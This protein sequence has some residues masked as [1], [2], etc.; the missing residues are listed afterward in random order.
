MGYD[1]T[2]IPGDQG[3]SSPS[4]AALAL[5]WARTLA[6]GSYVPMS[7][8]QTRDYLR[9]LTER[10]VAA[11]SGPSVDTQAASTVG[12]RL[13]AGGFTGAQTLSRTFEVLGNAL[14]ALAT[15]AATSKPPPAH[16]G[17]IIEL[18]GALAAGYTWALRMR[19]PVS[20]IRTVAGELA[21]ADGGQAEDNLRGLTTLG[22]R[23][24][25]YDFGGGIGGLR[26][27]ADLSVHTVRIA[28]PVSE[29][30]AADPSRILSQAAQALVHIVRGAGVDVVAFPVDSAEQAACWPWIGANWALGALFGEPGPPAGI[31]SRL[32]HP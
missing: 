1:H 13:V 26:C 3:R 28:Q 18:L 19:A 20:A 21:G 2:G 16:C 24:G 7:L 12:A 14:P 23:A 6:T 4:S 11:L 32:R 9:D 15:G 17:R 10:L 25:L 5:E 27:V 8:A 22:V 31:E 30:V 29:Q